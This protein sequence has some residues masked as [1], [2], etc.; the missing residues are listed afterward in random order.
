MRNFSLGL[1]HN[2][3][4]EFKAAMLNNYMDI[5]KL[6]VNMQQVEDNKKK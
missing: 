1:S 2:L 4:L 5:S 6:V 3:V